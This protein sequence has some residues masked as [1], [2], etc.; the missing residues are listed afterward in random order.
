MGSLEKN[1][2]K[3]NV[4]CDFNYIVFDKDKENK[5]E[6]FLTLKNGSKFLPWIF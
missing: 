4:G 6:V 5:E 3:I 2:I 1:V